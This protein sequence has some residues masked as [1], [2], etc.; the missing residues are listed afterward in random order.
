M[1]AEARFEQVRRRA[2][3]GHRVRVDLIADLFNLSRRKLQM[4]DFSL[5][6]PRKQT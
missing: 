1:V 5:L 4:S 2:V 3:F 6:Y